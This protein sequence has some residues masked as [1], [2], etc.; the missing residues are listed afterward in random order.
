MQCELPILFQRF[1]RNLDLDV[2]DEA[3]VDSEVLKYML[4]QR[5][6]FV[7]KPEALEQDKSTFE[8]TLEYTTQEYLSYDYLFKNSYLR[9]RKKPFRFRD[10]AALEKKGFSVKTNIFRCRKCKSCLTL[11]A[12]EL[13]TRMTHE[14]QAYEEACWLTLTYNDKY[15]DVTKDP[16]YY[17]KLLDEIKHCRS[18]VHNTKN[19]VTKEE[20]REKL[21]VL[22]AEKEKIKR[23]PNVLDYEHIQ[24]FVKH[25]RRELSRLY[26]KKIRFSVVGEYGSKN[27]R[28]HWH[29]FIYGWE[30]KD[31]EETCKER[32]SY[33]GK[34]GNCKVSPFL[35]KI[36]KKGFVNVDV[37]LSAAA[38]YY[39][40]NY[41]LKKIDSGEQQKKPIFK[42]S[43][44]LGKDWVLSNLKQIIDGEGVEIER[45]IKE[46]KELKYEKVKV[47][48]PS[49]YI[50]FLKRLVDK[51]KDIEG[52]SE[53]KQELR[54][55]LFEV[56]SR[57]AWVAFFVERSRISLEKVFEFDWKKPAEA[58]L[59]WL[60]R[61]YNDSCRRKL[62]S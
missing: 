47:P 43:L 41:C 58:A 25:L 40:S 2:A 29:M 42:H 6:N 45:P 48:I 57:E 33:S 28:M 53:R 10:Y 3:C 24:L 15:C 34:E 1:A 56:A 38:A 9:S 51:R 54:E 62:E 44:G 50:E 17:M 39:T 27:G 61:G 12:K 35:S 46:G 60:K 11:A 36:W 14:L 32:S 30:P 52:V 23:V 4:K 37:G 8:K 49:A 16:T 26:G 20:Y 59:F 21:K 55:K 13:G 7:I 19:A 18:V 22:K 5:R 31:L